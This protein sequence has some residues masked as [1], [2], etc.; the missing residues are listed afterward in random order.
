MILLLELLLEI[1]NKCLEKSVVNSL[2]S[3]GGLSKRNRMT[4]ME[5]SSPT[6]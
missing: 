4:V 5:L 3:L 6:Y 1:R 2:P